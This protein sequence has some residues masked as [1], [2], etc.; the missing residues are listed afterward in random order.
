MAL[1]KQVTKLWPTK[2][3]RNIFHPGINLK[4]FE[5]EDEVRSQDFKRDFASGANVG[6][7]VADIVAEAQAYIDHYK[8]ERA[9]YVTGGYD[10]AVASID[11]QL[12]V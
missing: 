6:D 8:E 5:D 7:I 2:D 11:S 9:M 3:S 10:T 1:T 12:E 4:L